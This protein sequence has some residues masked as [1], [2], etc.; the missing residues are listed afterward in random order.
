MILAVTEPDDPH[1]DAVL[2]ALA[3]MGAPTARLDLAS[4]PRQ[5]AVTMRR[6]GAD[7]GDRLLGAGPDGGPLRLEEVAAVWWRRPRWAVPHAELAGADAAFAVEQVHSALS[8]IWGSHPVAWMNEPWAED[9]ASHKGAQLAWAEAAGLAVPETIITSAP[10]DARAFLE[11]LGDRPCIH[12]P[13]RAD[14]AGWRSTR[15]M[16]ARDRERLD[17][18][19][20]GPAILQAY[21]PGVDVR[22]TCAGGRM[23]A[24]AIDARR[25][26]SPQDFRP[27]Y[28]DAQVT[29]FA[30]PAEVARALGRYL[31]AARLRYAAVDFRLDEEGRLFF[32]EANSSGQWL[33]LEDRTGQPIT[34][35]VAQAL[36]DSAREVTGAA[37]VRLP[38]WQGTSAGRRTA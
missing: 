38:G 21:V 23:L 8:G 31:D 3:R 11:A 4:L 29:A 9:R 16:R 20:F 37:P 6:G 34:A 19:R 32:L 26:S 14:K 17:D 25:T 1:A 27:V 18:L 35:A 24:T 28:A 10:A 15:A 2:D 5:V 36:S 13:L 7:R 33:F 30:L 12:K 22:V